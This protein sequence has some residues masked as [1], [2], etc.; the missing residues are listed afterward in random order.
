MDDQTARAWMLDIRANAIFITERCIA[1]LAILGD[2]GPSSD[3]LR[4]A[5]ALQQLVL[6]P[7]Q[8]RQ[9]GAAQDGLYEFLSDDR[10]LQIMERLINHVSPCIDALVDY[11][12]YFEV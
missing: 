11:A 10:M 7:L 6:E 8:R 9:Y 5:A 3:G 1:G 4:K 2:A 12:D